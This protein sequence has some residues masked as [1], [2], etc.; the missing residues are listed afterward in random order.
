MAGKLS[1]MQRERL[2]GAMQIFLA[3]KRFEGCGG[4]EITEEIKVT[5]AAQACMLSGRLA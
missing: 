1:E 3:E 5:V 4:Q 2:F